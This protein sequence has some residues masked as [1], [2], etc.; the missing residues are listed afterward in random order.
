[1]R[2]LAKVVQCPTPNAALDSEPADIFTLVFL[3]EDFV[4][5][6]NFGVGRFYFDDIQMNR[7]SMYRKYL[8]KQVLN[9]EKEL[10][11]LGPSSFPK[12]EGYITTLMQVQG[13]RNVLQPYLAVPDATVTDGVDDDGS[14]K[15]KCCPNGLPW[16]FVFVGWL[17]VFA[18]SGVS[19][20]FTMMYGLTYGKERSI[21]WLISI[22]VSF[23]E[24]LFFTQPLKVREAREHMMFLSFVVVI[25]ILDITYWNV[26]M[27]CDFFLFIYFSSF[28]STPQPHF[29]CFAWQVLGF[30][31][32]FAL[33]IKSINEEEVNYYQLMKD[34][35]LTYTGICKTKK[36]DVSLFHDQGKNVII[37]QSFWS[38]E[39]PDDVRISRRDSTSIYYQPPAL[40]EIEK[41]KINRIKNQKAFALIWEIISKVIYKLCSFF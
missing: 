5:Q 33:V 38:T 35:K 36:L 22:S 14:T 6:Q 23:F 40:S 26:L 2:Y 10:R 11:L 41:M 19:A 16:W 21:N 15:K 29:N 17:L 20:Y 34:M 18:S 24:S 31:V 32:F 4:R 9:L 1:M 28:L 12:P 8:Y 13:M 39:D 37:M 3:L 25:N 30:A 7:F 27:E